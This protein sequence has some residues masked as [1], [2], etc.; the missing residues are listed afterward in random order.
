MADTGAVGQLRSLTGQQV[1]R[2]AIAI[3][4]PDGLREAAAAGVP[5]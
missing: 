1:P 2:A 4:W 3:A 5:A